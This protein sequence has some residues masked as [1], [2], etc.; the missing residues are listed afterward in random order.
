MAD[1]LY[2]VLVVLGM[3]L[4]TVLTRSAFLLLPTRWQ[5]PPAALE[6]L[7]YAPIAAIA[8]IV[9]PDLIAWRPNTDSNIAS[10]VFNPKLIAAVFAA[11][12]HWKYRNMLLTI[13]CGMAA[14][15]AL[16]YLLPLIP[17]LV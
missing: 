7:K 17:R 13:A 8:A 5:L 15:W 14:F 3:A 10:A 11:L 6:A 12:I 4:A 9:L 16:R 2:F 1:W